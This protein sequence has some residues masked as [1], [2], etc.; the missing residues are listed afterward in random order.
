[1]FAISTAKDDYLAI[2]EFIV[3]NG[4]KALAHGG[5]E[6]GTRHAG[7]LYRTAGDAAARNYL[8]KAIEYYLDAAL[9]DTD[10]S[11]ILMQLENFYKEFWAAG[12][13]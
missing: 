4:P 13:T 3:R 8:E 10:N 2:D 9:V 12:S 1:M 6:Y 5:D 7:N 11:A